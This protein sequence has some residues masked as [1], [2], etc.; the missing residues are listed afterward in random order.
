MKLIRLIGARPQII[1]EAILNQELEKEGIGE[2]LH[3]QA[4]EWEGLSI[5]LIEARALGIPIV[6]TDAGSN[7]EIVENNVSGLIVPIKDPKTLAKSLYNLIMDDQM[8]KKF[9]KEATIKAQQF[10]IEECTKKHI[11]MYKELLSYRK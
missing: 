10:T 8:R 1:K 4:S 7:S 2:I 5:S 6:A 9:S 3:I 11:K